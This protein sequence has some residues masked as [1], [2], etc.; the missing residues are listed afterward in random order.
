MLAGYVR[1]R[2]YSIAIIDAEA[3]RLSPDRIALRVD[4]MKPR[5][6][7][8]V[9]Q[10][11]Q[12]SASTQ[13]MTGA[14][15]AKVAIKKRYPGQ[16]II[17][18]GGHCAALPERTL[19]E[20]YV[21]YVC[22]G[23]GFVTLSDL[24]GGVAPKNVPDLYSWRDDK[25]VNYPLAKIP[26]IADL[27]KDAIGDVWDLL[28]MDLYRAHP[29]QCFGDFSKRKPYASIY[30][31]LGCPFSCSF[32]MINA[33]FHSNR[34]RTRSAES[35]VNEMMM[36]HEQYGVSTF[37]FADEMFVL[38]KNHYRDICARLVDY[39]LGE[40][41]NIWAYAR[42]DTINPDN[43]GLLRAAGIQWLAL[44]IESGSKFVRDGA[45]KA[46]RND[47]IIGVVRQIEGAG[48]NVIGNYIFGL[49]DDDLASMQQ[50]LALSLECNTAFANFY[51]AMAYPG[52]KLYEDS[53]KNQCDLPKLWSGYSQHSY[54]CMPLG[55]DRLSPADVLSFRDNAF[56]IYFNNPTYLAMVEKKFGAETKA[57]V[58]KMAAHTL[59]RKLL[60]T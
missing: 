21:D 9:A 3:E 22:S 40:K 43:L 57:Y 4:E 32:C 24:L 49:P 42:V 37:K 60:G 48:I 36:L 13:S 20:E 46:L 14:R 16:K 6:V 35:V 44:G 29:W 53:L 47:D 23:E 2:G 59:P 34:Y 38:R 12:P 15:A 45:D 52:S 8:I 31:S 30:T 39:G 33:P 50:T 27:D 7:A 1:D 58:Q 10:G 5:L 19:R 26:L 17:M 54:D 25:R 56:Q 11:H 28:P 51:S 55:N 18:L 41:I